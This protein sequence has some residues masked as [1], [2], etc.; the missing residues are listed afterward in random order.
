MLCLWLHSQC[1]TRNPTEPLTKSRCIRPPLDLGR[2][3]FGSEGYAMYEFMAYT[4]WENDGMAKKLGFNYKACTYNCK[5][6]TKR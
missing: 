1:V 3:R 2:N 5:S 4:H 6:R